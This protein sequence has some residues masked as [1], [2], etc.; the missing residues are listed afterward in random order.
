MVSGPFT[1]AQL[2]RV[3]G[4]SLDDIRLYEKLGL[5]QPLRRRRGRSGDLAYHREH[6]E[7]LRFIRRAL[8]VGYE[9]ADI[10]KLVSPHALTTCRDVHDLT[11]QRARQAQET[12]PKRAAALAQLVEKCPRVGTRADCPILAGL[13]VAA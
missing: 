13:E 2:A 9:L 8:S 10:A 12:E 1:R 4:A 7:R 5:L 6:V 3:V 11:L